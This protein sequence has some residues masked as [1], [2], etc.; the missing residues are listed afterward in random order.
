MNVSIFTTGDG[1][2]THVRPATAHGEAASVFL[3]A[4]LD[5]S[6]WFSCQLNVPTIRG[7]LRGKAWA[8]VLLFYIAMSTRS[9]VG[10]E[11]FMAMVVSYL[12]V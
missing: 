6:L 3:A 2:E 12:E 9:F 4:Y 11:T 7:D 1:R 8:Q 5:A 10:P